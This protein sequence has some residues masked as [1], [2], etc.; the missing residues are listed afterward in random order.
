MSRRRLFLS[1]LIAAAIL[2]VAVGCEMLPVLHTVGRP[3]S[4]RPALP[5]LPEPQ[6]RDSP[7]R[8]A[9]ISY[10]KGAVSFQAAG[11]E[12]WSR[13]ELNRPATEGDALWTD[14]AAGAE[15]HLGSAAIRMDAR[16]ALD[17][18]R[19]DDR[20]V[21][22]RVT[23]G[24][25]GVTVRR[26]S[27]GEILEIDTPGAAVTFSQ[28]GQYRIEIQPDMETTVVTA[29]SGD[30]EVATTRLS[31]VVHAGQRVNVVGTDAGE[32]GLAKAF[33]PDKFD[34]FCQARDRREDGCVAS[35]YVSPDAI[36]AYDLDEFGE[37]RVD[38][39]WGNVWTPRRL[40]EG[41]APYR[42]GH[43]AWVEGWG[44]TWIDDAA[45]G[46]APFHYGRWAFLDDAWSWVPGPPNDRA[47]YAP[48]L[49][50]FVGGGRR[51]Y[52]Y[53]YW[54]GTPGIAW[55]PIG[56][57]EVYVPPYR[58]SPA[59]LTN[60]NTSNTAMKDPTA[61]QEIDVARQNYANLA[62]TGAVTAVPREV[63]VRGQFIASANIA[64]AA[65]QA[66]SAVINGTTPPVAP[67]EVSS[68][69]RRDR[70]VLPPPRINPVDTVVGRRDLPPRP[71]SFRRRQP[72]LDAHP[73][74]PLELSELEALRSAANELPR[75]EVRPARVADT[76]A[77]EWVAPP[78]LA[79][80]PEQIKRDKRSDAQRL[81][82]IQR[83][84]R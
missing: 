12:T 18:L 31:F 40:P 15:L 71:A 28:A 25:I 57:G 59:Y 7:S 68:S 74:R 70:F 16:T 52:R 67:L 78:L 60:I 33:A 6:V 19:F 35:L 10:L 50:V 43:W 53:F 30:T 36:G 22:L 4:A 39:Q 64:V 49:A 47:V 32:Y 65:P 5:S 23:K 8:L 45:W 75:S 29:R 46:F 83:E 81:R 48:A 58:C 51:G 76:R 34:E 17:F 2:L 73:G 69:P 61:I 42:F 20:I 55:F 80:T 66:L 62:V 82:A 38:A 24:V 77:R 11:T 9:R 79:R 1:S 41:W 37:W 21:Q 3:P 63:F 13:A 26:V 54:V 84:N 72:F 14:V 44:W 56:P 27:P